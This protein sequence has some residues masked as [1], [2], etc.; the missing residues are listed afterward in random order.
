MR[1]GD[2]FCRWC[3]GVGGAVVFVW[4][5]PSAF[6]AE[7]TSTEQLVARMQGTWS[8][9]VDGRLPETTAVVEG[10]TMTGYSGGRVADV[11]TFNALGVEEEKLVVESEEGRM[12]V[13]FDDT[14]T[15]IFT[16]VDE[17]NYIMRFRRI[18]DVELDLSG[19]AEQKVQVEDSGTSP[20]EAVSEQAEDSTMT[21]EV[22]A[23]DYDVKQKSDLEALLRCQTVSGDLNFFAAEWLT[24]ID[25]PNLT[26]VG[27]DLSINVNDNLNLSTGLS[28]LTTVGGELSILANGR[29][30]TSLA[31]LSH[32]TSVGGKLD[33]SDNDCLPQDEAIEFAAAL[34]VGGKVIV[35]GNGDNLPCE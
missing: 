16:L 32:L 18:D 3:L 10:N 24:S 31:G 17:N 7:S 4:A 23:G 5:G 22:C 12:L 11:D 21:G 25:L 28:A 27:D 26:T 29:R 33:I 34:D 15:M 2:L 19:A 20:S 1:K 14:G 30:L 35:V 9:V 6:G 13:H 8:L